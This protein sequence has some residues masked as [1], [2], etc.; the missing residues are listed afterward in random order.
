MKGNFIININFFYL[1]FV[2]SYLIEKFRGE[3]LFLIFLHYFLNL[4]FSFILSEYFWCKILLIFYINF[5][6]LNFLQ[7]SLNFFIKKHPMNVKDQ[8]NS[9][10]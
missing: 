4:V 5:L 8:N 2:I 7:R 3:R 9:L 1:L 6:I 10:K